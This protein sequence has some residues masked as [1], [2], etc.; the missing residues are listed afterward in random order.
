MTVAEFRER[1][2]PTLP[3]QP[4]VYRFI[5]L[6]DEVLYVGK[7]KNLWNRVNSYFVGV[8]EKS[9]KHKLLLRQAITIVFTLVN[10]EKDALLLENNLIKEY[11][12]RYNVS[13]KDGKTYPFICIKNE[14]FPR[15]FITRK[16]I[17]DGSEYFGPYLTGFEAYTMMDLFKEL[18]PLRTCSLSLSK[19]NI[20]SGKFR[21]CMEFHIGNCKAPCVAKETEENYNSYI[22][23]IKKM[24]KGHVAIVIRELKNQM[25]QFA[26][27][28]EYEKANNFKKRI[29][30][31]EQFQS[32]STIVNPAV[33]DVDVVGMVQEGNMYFIN[34]LKIVNGSVIQAQNVELKQQLDES[35]EEILAFAVTNLRRQ[36]DSHS[37]E[38]IAPFEFNSGLEDEFAITVPKIGDKKYLLDLSLKNALYFRNKR[39]SSEDNIKMK[40]EEFSVLKLLQQDFRLSET[41]MHIECFDNSNFQGDYAV[42]AMVVFKNGKP[43]KK[44]YRH[45]NIKTVVGPDDFASMEEVIERRYKRLIEEAQPLPQLILIDGGKGQLSSAFGVIEKLGLR[46][47]VAM[48][49]IAKKLEE[50]YVPND[51]LPLHIS[52]KSASLKLIQQ[53]RDE[54]HRF[55]I[56]HHRNRRD[57]ATLMPELTKIKGIGEK[58]NIELLRHFKS[59][60]NLKLATEAELLQV[61][62]KKKVAILVAYF[63][64]KV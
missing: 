51:P 27:D 52:K 57:K 34:Y 53:L 60:E 32:K 20:E 41:P 16:M 7:A 2:Q 8:D 30:R 31:L 29:E 28:L 25:L 48:V 62:D 22:D 63:A 54:A 11:Q 36:F 35:K 64:T 61:V 3:K 50:I 49:S 6:N 26:E 59:I 56:T 47:K 45:F 40:T 5:G 33:N 9:T 17:R 12:P 24:L 21:A 14:R 42:S 46:G 1:I 4:G 44:D 43:S 37:P 55:G 15:V 23:E 58:T 39:L 19:K 38:L 18:F 13:L 10:S